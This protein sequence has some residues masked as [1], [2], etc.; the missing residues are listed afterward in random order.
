MRSTGAC[1]DGGVRVLHTLLEIDIIDYEKNR[2]PEK[3]GRVVH[4]TPSL[5]FYSSQ[6]STE[7]AL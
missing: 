2:I 1:Q 5:I 7:L 3:S 4:T 6:I